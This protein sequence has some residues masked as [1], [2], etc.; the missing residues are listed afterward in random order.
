MPIIED[1]QKHAP[2]FGAFEILSKQNEG[3]KADHIPEY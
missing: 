2:I 3:T 1:G